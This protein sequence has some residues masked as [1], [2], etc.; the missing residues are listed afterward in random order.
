[1][2]Q[3]RSKI[4]SQN[5]SQNQSQIRSQ[6]QSQIRSQNR[7]QIRSHH[8]HKDWMGK[9]PLFGKV[10]ILDDIR[11]DLIL[12]ENQLPF[13]VLEQLYNLSGMSANFVYIT[14]NYFRSLSIGE[15][16]PGESPKHFTDFLSMVLRKPEEYNEVRYVYSASQLSEVGIQFQVN[17]NEGLLDLTYLDDGTFFMPNLNINDDIEMILRNIMAFEHCHLPDIDIINQC[18]QI[19]DFLINTEKDVKVLV[20]NKIIVNWMGDV[21]AVATMINS[22][23]SNLP[24]PNFS[25]HYFSICNS[26]NNFYKNPY[27]KYK[28]I[29][30]Q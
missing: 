20:D 5:R 23:G 9:N 11:A 6:N 14:Y 19:L 8:K 12:L 26:L 16:C 30:L 22:L 13:F 21:N 29:F 17:S 25:S 15:V 4:Q 24:M 1:M 28:V 3:N 18:L 27:N 10:W 7:S 2:S